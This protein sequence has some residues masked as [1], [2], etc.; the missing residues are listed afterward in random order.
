MLKATF[1]KHVFD[2]KKPSG[3]SRG[4]LTKKTSYFIKVWNIL[5][6]N[7]FGIGECSFIEGLSIDNLDLIEE[8]LSFACTNINLPI[9][10]LSKKCI[11][12]PALVFGLE[13]ALLDL[14]NGG[15][16]A[17]FRSPF[18]MSKAPINING[19]IW[20]GDK[21][22]MLK[23]IETK[24]EQGFSCLKMKIGAIDFDQ[25]ISLLK[26]IRTQFDEHD[27]ELRVDANGAFSPTNAMDK[28]NMLSEYEIHSIEQPIKSGQW[29]EMRKLCDTSPID[30][31]LDEELIGIQGDDFKTQLLK[32]IQP[33][34]IIL[35]PS[36][37]GGFTATK[38][39]TEIAGQLS[40]PWWI[41]SALESNVGLNAIAQFVSATYNPLPQGLGTGQLYE[42][43][44]PSP[45]T[46][47]GEQL[48]FDASSNWDFS[49]LHF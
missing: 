35:K 19:L 29:E 49:A 33:Q 17:I 11:A 1:T 32:A 34:F 43:N 24:I 2:F 41:T 7:I 38:E 47:N 21:T 40:I 23:Q 18:G 46:L 27:L 12:F 22:E 44:I 14:Q 25:E 16:R 4:V 26:Q 45:L 8:Q 3:T 10:E 20:M 6:E 9:D 28:L 48:S 5:D 36:L 15:K 37:I 31:A 42:Q 39:W 13:T 30:I